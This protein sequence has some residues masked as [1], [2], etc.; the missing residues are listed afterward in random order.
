MRT[1]VTIDDDIYRKAKAAAAESGRPL[2]S[3]IEDALRLIL[4]AEAEQ[5]ELPPLPHFTGDGLQ[6]GVNIDSNADLWDLLDEGLEIH[7][8]R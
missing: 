2:G 1:T 5:R 4:I 8:L 6:P 7:E 3:L